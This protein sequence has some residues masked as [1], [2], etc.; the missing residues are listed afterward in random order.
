MGFSV[1][2]TVVLEVAFKA[3]CAISVGRSKQRYI[4]VSNGIT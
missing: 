3:I 2:T 4:Y 1:R